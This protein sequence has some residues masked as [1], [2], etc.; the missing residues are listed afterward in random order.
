MAMNRVIL[1]GKKRKVMKV[2][3]A[4]ILNTIIDIFLLYHTPFLSKFNGSY[5]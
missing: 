1:E 2:I 3:S 4:I 5:I